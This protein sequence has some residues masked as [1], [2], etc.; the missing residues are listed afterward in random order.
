MAEN[1]N[2]L[3][4]LEFVDL[5]TVRNSEAD[6]FTLWLATE[7]NLVLLGDVTVFGSANRRIG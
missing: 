7:E 6:D 2:H 5:R 4:R 1:T 3:G